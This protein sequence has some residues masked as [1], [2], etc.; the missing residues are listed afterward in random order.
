LSKAFAH[1]RVHQTAV[2]MGHELYEVVMHDN[3]WSGQ[4]KRVNPGA[5]AKQLEERFVQRNLKLLL[6][7]ARATLTHMLNTIPDEA[8]KREIY[9]ALILDAT[10][11]YGRKH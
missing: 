3:E 2:A 6:P 8:L 5:T 10:L 4:W 9:D 1:W 11:K 7:Q